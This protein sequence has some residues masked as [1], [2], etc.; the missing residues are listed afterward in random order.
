MYSHYLVVR[1]KKNLHVIFTFGD[2]IKTLNILQ[3][4]RFQ[5]SGYMTKAYNL[6]F[7]CVCVFLKPCDEPEHRVSF[8][9]RAFLQSYLD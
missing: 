6:C 9:P 1:F 3:S 5:M 7:V 2:R 4:L 8:A